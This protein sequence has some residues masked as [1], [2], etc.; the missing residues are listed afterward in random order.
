MATRPPRRR[1]RR[2]VVEDAPPTQVIE[3]G[4]P[5][6]PYEEPPPSRELWPWLLALA[7]LVIAGLLA[8]YFLTRD[9]G[10]KS[11][12]AVPSVVGLQRGVAIRRIRDRGLV[13]S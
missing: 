9:D 1:L 6:P 7:I 3:D 8:G 4:P 13:P 2:R 12:T 11:S 5:P 10:E